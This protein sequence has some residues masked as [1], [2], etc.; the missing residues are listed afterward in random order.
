M[1]PG[2]RSKF[3]APMFEPGVFRKQMY[4]ALNS[5]DIVRTFR[6]PAVIQIPHSDSAPGELRPLSPV[7]TPLITARS[8]TPQQIML[9]TTQL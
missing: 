4:T 1:A 8:D 5:Y 2:A 3:G 9:H 6:R 7:V